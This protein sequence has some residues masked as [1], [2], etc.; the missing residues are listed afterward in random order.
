M[1]PYACRGDPCCGRAEDDPRVLPS[2]WCVACGR[3]PFGWP[4]RCVGDLALAC[5]TGNAPTFVAA[6]ALGKSHR[7]T[8][9]AIG[10]L[11]AHLD[12]KSQTLPM[13]A[14]IACI[15]IASLGV[16]ALAGTLLFYWI[17]AF[18][19]GEAR[20]DAYW[21][22]AWAKLVAITAIPLGLCLTRS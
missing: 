21:F 2:R 7:E 16:V 4:R 19:S 18:P 14:R 6:I 8:R 17:N 12:S 3:I 10:L 1:G 20:P 9:H 22:S 15:V 11:V 5:P 13:L